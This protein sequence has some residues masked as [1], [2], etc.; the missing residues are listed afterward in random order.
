LNSVRVFVVDD[1]EQ[2]RSAVSAIVDELEGFV[3]VGSA[4][5]GEQSLHLI[6]PTR[7]DLVLMD[8]NLP[9]ISGIEATRKLTAAPGAPVVVLLSTHDEGELDYRN[10]GAAAYINKSAFG[11]CRLVDVWTSYSGGNGHSDR[12]D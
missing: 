6:P 4:E 7:A 12:Q 11:P 1:H 9:G 5:S 3:V 10:S 2:F 8:V